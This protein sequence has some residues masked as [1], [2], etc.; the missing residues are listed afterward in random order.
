MT[1]SVP[2]LADSAKLEGV[3]L[4]YNNLTGDFPLDYFTKKTFLKLEFFNVNY[5]Y[6]ANEVNKLVKDSF[7]NSYTTKVI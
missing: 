5:N 6:R 1:G 7:G 4:S 2:T 3:D